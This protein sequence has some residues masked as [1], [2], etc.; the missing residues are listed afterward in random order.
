MTTPIR[1][2]NTSP[3][4]AFDG[5]TIVAP[6]GIVQLGSVPLANIAQ[7]GATSGQA[8]AWSGSAWAPAGSTVRTTTV[9]ISTG[10]GATGSAVVTGLTWVTASSVIVA[11][12]I[13]HPTG[14]S[15]QSAANAGAV[16]TVGAFVAGV[17]FTVYV[18]VPGGTASTIRVAVVGV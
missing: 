13:D 7:S 18:N 6:Q 15:A 1:I 5:S 9:N 11:G 12:F 16:V 4:M 10:G 14:L 8:L 17:G 2:P 3:L